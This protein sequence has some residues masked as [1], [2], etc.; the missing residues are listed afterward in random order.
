MGSLIALVCAQ[1]LAAAAPAAQTLAAEG[2]SAGGELARG[3]IRVTA[4]VTATIVHAE[5]L[6]GGTA[7][8]ALK[9]TVRP[10]W[11]GTVN[12]EFE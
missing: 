5:T 2:P 6:R 1:A 9:R 7:A 3:G 12:T 4:L 10:G 8:G 11:G